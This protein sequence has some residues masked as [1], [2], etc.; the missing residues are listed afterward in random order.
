MKSVSGHAASEPA[1]AIRR[2]QRI[3]ALD[4]IERAQDRLGLRVD[5]IANAP[6][7]VADPDRGARQFGGERVDLDAMHDLGADR[8][9]ARLQAHGFA[10]EIGLELH[11]LDPLQRQVKKIA[12]AAGRVENGDAAQ[13]VNELAN[14]PPRP[15]PWRSRVRGC[16]CLSSAWS[17]SRSIASSAFVHSSRSGRRITGSTII[18]ILSGSV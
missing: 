17:T 18:M 2:D 1:R 16:P 6:L 5:A 11:V 13:P 7:N 10:F 3:A 12:G 15:P 9:H 14:V 8:R 4:R